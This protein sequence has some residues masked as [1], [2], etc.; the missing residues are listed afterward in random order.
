MADITWTNVTN[1]APELS[2]AP[3]ALQTAMLASVNG[4]IVEAQ[5]PS[6]ARAEEA[7]AYLAAHMATLLRRG[8][9]GSVG[10]LSS[11]TVGQVSKT[12]ATP[13]STASSYDATPY[14]SMYKQLLRENPYRIGVV[15]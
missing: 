11:I 1:I 9:G 15:T 12:F 4:R 13:G 2:T 5:W 14:G 8:G 3:V 6:V 7:R 10:P